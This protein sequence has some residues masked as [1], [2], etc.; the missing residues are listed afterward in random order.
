MDDFFQKCKAI[1]KR[2][3]SLLI[4]KR[5]D[6]FNTII[7]KKKNVDREK[8]LFVKST[9]ETKITVQEH[10]ECSDS[11][12]KEKRKRRSNRVVYAALKAAHLKAKENTF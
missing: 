5:I 4:V 1:F 10:A 12:F 8:S 9:E 11:K 6:C 2:N 7:M 3:S